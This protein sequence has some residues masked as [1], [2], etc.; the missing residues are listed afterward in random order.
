MTSS[1]DVNFYCERSW[2]DKKWRIQE[3]RN[4]KNEDDLTGFKDSD[5]AW[6][7][8]F[9]GIVHPTRFQVELNHG[10]RSLSYLYVTIE[11]DYSQSD[12]EMKIKEAYKAD[13]KKQQ[14]CTLRWS[15]Y[16]VYPTVKVREL[17]KGTSQ[18]LRGGN[19]FRMK[20]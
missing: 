19:H 13:Y 20:C 10:N 9:P 12:L 14:S 2:K 6:N 4:R 17:K 5:A 1:A 8:M 3:V 16:V 7:S 11:D 15:R 18:T